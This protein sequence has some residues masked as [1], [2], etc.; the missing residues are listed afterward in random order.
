MENATFLY[1]RLRHFAGQ[2]ILE[3]LIF[4]GSGVICRLKNDETPCALPG[5]RNEAVSVE[6]CVLNTPEISAFSLR[7]AKTSGI[8]RFIPC[9]NFKSLAEPLKLLMCYLLCFLFGPWPLKPTFFQPL[10]QKK[11]TVGIPVETFDPIIPS[12]TE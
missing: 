9:L 1:L 6:L 11:K 4:H 7:K 8:Y 10:I 5:M 3:K 12:T 2:E